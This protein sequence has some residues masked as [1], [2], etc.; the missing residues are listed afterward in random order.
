MIACVLDESGT[1]IE[2]HE[3]EDGF[4]EFSTDAR[5]ALKNRAPPAR[6]IG[7]PPA[8]GLLGM[9]GVPGR[10]VATLRQIVYSSMTKERRDV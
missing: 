2:T 5:P 10:V 3:S 8:R 1:L 6:P 7:P 4:R 9:I